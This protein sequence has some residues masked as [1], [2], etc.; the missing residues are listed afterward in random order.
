M[1][2]GEFFL[3]GE[4]V[5]LDAAGLPEFSFDALVDGSALAVAPC[6]F[7]VAP[8]CDGERGE[9]ITGKRSEQ[10]RRRADEL[11]G[12]AEHPVTH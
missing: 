5:H 1:D 11:V 9:M 3:C 7:G 10:T 2:A 4:Q 8:L 6:D 12:E